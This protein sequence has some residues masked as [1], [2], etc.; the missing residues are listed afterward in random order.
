M[1]PNAIQAAVAAT[2]ADVV[3]GP[4]FVSHLDQ[5]VADSVAIMVFI[6]RGV[7]TAEALT[8]AIHPLTTPY[9]QTLC[10]VTAWRDYVARNIDH[11]PSSWLRQ[12]SRI[13]RDAMTF[14]QLIDVNVRCR[15]LCHS[16]VDENLN[17]LTGSRKATA[18]L[19]QQIAGRRGALMVRGSCDRGGASAKKSSSF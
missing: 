11:Q 16:N 15:M 19:E 7:A 6:A 4:V 13:V 17:M 3:Y 18:E 10:E 9:P 8:S 1:D 12:L 5:K 2:G 14:H